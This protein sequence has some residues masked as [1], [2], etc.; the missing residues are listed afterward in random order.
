MRIL[1]LVLSL[2]PLFAQNRSDAL[3]VIAHGAPAGEWNDRVIRMMDKVDW[4]GPKGVGFLMGRPGDE[5]LDR[6]A[7]RLDRAGVKRI[8]IVPLLVSSY[9]AHY[10]QIRY[11]AG[12]IEHFHSHEGLTVGPPLKTK[13]E[14]VVARAMDDDP[15]ISRILADQVRSVST[16]PKR[17]T[18]VLI[19]HGPNEEDENAKWMA[20]LRVHGAY[21]EKT[22]AFRRIE[23]ATLRDDAPKPVKDAAISYMRDVVKKSAADSTVIVLPV[24]I[25]VG[26]VQAEI[27]ELL[28]GY[29]YRISL[30]GLAD[31]PL[32][33]EWI[34]SRAG[35]PQ[36]SR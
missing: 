21:L 6:V 13:A 10:E 29:E 18:L 32:V 12:K 4:P 17:E 20:C 9:S 34:R 3:L 36:P 26:Q 35:N 16:D 1:A 31:H 5:P 27:R 15:L 25:S 22:L 8:V 24:L 33:V 19:T 30:A 7:A 11:Y 23:Y 14:L 2:A 28:N